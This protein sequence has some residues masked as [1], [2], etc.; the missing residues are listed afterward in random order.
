MIQAVVL[1]QVEADTADFHLLRPSP[2][3]DGGLSE[4]LQQG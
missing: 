3:M 2:E 1:K 4:R